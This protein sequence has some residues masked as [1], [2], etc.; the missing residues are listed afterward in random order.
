MQGKEKGIY[1]FFVFHYRRE[2][3]GKCPGKGLVFDI[4]NG[5]VLIQNVS[6]D[7]TPG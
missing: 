3:I 6:F 4:D 7:D 1:N 5:K 2:D